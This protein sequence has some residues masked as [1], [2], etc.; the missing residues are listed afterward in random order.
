M[1]EKTEEKKTLKII[2]KKWK[3]C[4]SNYFTEKKNVICRR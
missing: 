3:K 2:E 4:S 1:T